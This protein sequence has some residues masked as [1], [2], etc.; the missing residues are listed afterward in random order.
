[1][2]RGV[3]FLLLCLAASAPFLTSC[4]PGDSGGIRASG[5][6][7]ATDADL[8]F[9]L[10]GR[11]EAISVREGDSV[12]AGQQVAVLDRTEILARKRSAEAQLDAAKA[13]LWEMQAGFRE[14]EIGEGR[15]A[16]TQAEERRDDARRDRD[17]AQRLFEGGS[18][19]QEM[20]DKAATSFRVAEA[21]V[22]QARQRLLILQEGTRPERIAAQQALVSQAEA[23]VA[24]IE[25]T[26][27][28]A[29][30]TVP[31]PGL[32]TV[33]H[34]EPGETVSPGVPVLTVLDPEDRW[35]RI[36]VREDRIGEVSLGQSAII[37]S[38]TYPDQ[39]YD[40]EVV[41]ISSEAEFTPRNVQTTEERVKLVYAV[42]VRITGDP[43]HH[44]KP[45]IPADV[46]L[47]SP[48]S[49]AGEG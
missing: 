34:R 3:P 41:F 1:M 5:T 16:L 44:L 45:G 35:V 13:L 26:L 48:E 39:R 46:V 7:E 25:A 27:A 40:G 36:Y 17:R 23:A 18:I 49:D 20:L 47:P 24:Q 12:Q 15:A 37:S 21:S 43:S 14:E 29:T 10:A 9:Q 33:R 6:V 38:D 30:V 42:K 4:E 19:S 22:D 31:S 32:V 2:K 8:G 28:N 11:I